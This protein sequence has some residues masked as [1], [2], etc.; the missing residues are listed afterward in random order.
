MV[1]V[2][3]WSLI[4]NQVLVSCSTTVLDQFL[5]C[6][7]I[8]NCH[9]KQIAAGAFVQCCSEVRWAGSY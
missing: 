2:G 8:P 4:V 7:D 3:C 1:S 6:H 5:A 9:V